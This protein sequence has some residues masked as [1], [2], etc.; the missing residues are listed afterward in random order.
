MFT[1]YDYEIYGKLGEVKTYKRN[2]VGTVVLSCIILIGM[3]Q[4]KVTYKEFL[5][6]SFFI[7]HYSFLDK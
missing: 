5:I 7:R 3:V 4:L 2:I 1:E 6:Q